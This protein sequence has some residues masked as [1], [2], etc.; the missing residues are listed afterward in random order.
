MRENFNHRERIARRALNVFEQKAN[1]YGIEML[2]PMGVE[3]DDETIYAELIK[4]EDKTSIML[5]HRP[6]RLCFTKDETILLQIKGTEKENPDVVFVEVD[7]WLGAMEWN[8][9]YRHVCFVFVT[10]KDEGV[11]FAW[12]DELAF[13]T[14]YVPMRKFGFIPWQEK[15]KQLERI[16][17]DKNITTIEHRRGSGTPY[18][19]YKRDKLREFMDIQ[20]RELL[21]KYVAAQQSLFPEVAHVRY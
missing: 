16:F 20:K 2:R 18:F 5:R 6:D 7:S 17:P 19:M 13:K 1:Q 14:I 11:Y 21:S 3:F 15:K 8:K 4:R 12:A 10:I 9:V